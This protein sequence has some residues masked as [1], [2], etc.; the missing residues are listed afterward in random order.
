VSFTHYLSLDPPTYRAL[1]LGQRHAL[2]LP[3]EQGVAVG[4]QAI[5]RE[6]L[7]SV[8]DEP[9]PYTG[10]WLMRK[11]TDVLV[12]GPGLDAA[13]AVYSLGTTAD[14]ERAI[15]QFRRSLGIADRQGVA[16]DRFWRHQ[17]RLERERRT[18]LLRGH[19]A[20][21]RATGRASAEPRAAAKDV[22]T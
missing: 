15:V 12:G 8:G 20:V 19:E 4:D 5:M 21:V 1:A 9:G 10:A 14:N 18:R 17:E 2:V 6:Q 3:L 11:V 13:H 22:G 7:E 16:S